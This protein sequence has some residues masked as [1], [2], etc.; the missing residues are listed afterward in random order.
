MTIQMTS[1]ARFAV[2]LTTSVSIAEAKSHL[3]E[4]VARVEAGEDVV[5]TKR[6]VEVVRM[7]P[8]VPK[9]A[10]RIDWAAIRAFTSTLPQGTT[11]AGEYIREMRDEE[12]Y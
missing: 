3:S 2:E 6:G 8:I 7:I 10:T 4:I 5:I 9:K 1:S 12:R 11:S